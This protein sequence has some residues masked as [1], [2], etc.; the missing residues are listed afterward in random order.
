MPKKKA[1]AKKKKQRQP[2][3][4]QQPQGEGEV[5]SRAGRPGTIFAPCG[6]G[7]EAELTEHGDERALPN[8]LPNFV[9]SAGA[10]CMSARSD[11]SC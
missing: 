5:S 7:S 6:T 8:S 11:S 4:K 10:G 1:R 3:P 9:S 2:P